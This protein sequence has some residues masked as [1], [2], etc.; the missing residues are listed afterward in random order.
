MARTR[1]A[2]AAAVAPPARRPRIQI[3]ECDDL[4]VEEA[5]AY[6][7]L[8]VAKIGQFTSARR[9]TPERARAE[10]EDHLDGKNAGA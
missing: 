8:Y 10:A 4:T 1:R 6:G 5:G 9:S 2:P 7:H 3:V